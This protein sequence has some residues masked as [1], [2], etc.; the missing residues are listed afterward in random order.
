MGNVQSQQEFEAAQ[1][2]AKE[3]GRQEM[4]KKLEELD[5]VQQARQQQ[6]LQAAFEKGQAD[7]MEEGEVSDESR[8]DSGAV[9]GGVSV[10]KEKK[11][12]PEE[13]VI[14]V[15]REPKVK[16]AASS[17]RASERAAEKASLLDREAAAANELAAARR[18]SSRPGPADP[19]N[20]WS[21]RKQPRQK[22]ATEVAG[23]VTSSATSDSRRASS[24][25]RSPKRTVSESGFA[26]ER[27]RSKKPSISTSSPATPRSPDQ[28]SEDRQPPEWYRQMK[29]EGS[30][31]KEE[32]EAEPL[33]NGLKIQIRKAQDIIKK[34]QGQSRKAQI[35]L[36]PIFNEVRDKLH[37]VAF[38][39]VSK[40]GLRNT[41]ALDNEN[42]L[43]LI[44]DKRFDQG[45]SWPF[46]I[47]A[48]AE[49]L[50]NK[51]YREDFETDL[52][53]GIN[54]GKPKS[55]KDKDRND[56]SSDRLLDDY[57]K[58]DGNYYGNGKLLNGQWWPTQLT[59][60]RDGA[61]ASSQGGISGGSISL[62]E[63]AY[64]CIMSGGH[65]YGHDEDHGDWAW[66]CGTDC[67]DGTGNITESTLR[68][69]HS[70][71]KKNPVRLIRS[72]NLKSKW[73]PIK[74]F[75]YD[76]LYDVVEKERI[77]PEGNPRARYRFK[78]VRRDGQ[79]PIRGGDGPERRPTVQEVEAYEKDKRLRGF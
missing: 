37:K 40:K 49:E 33:L 50:Y 22:A 77:D 53:R 55:G 72:H 57:P 45:V 11:E 10:K 13:E 23:R 35:E 7:A 67:T 47:R 52:M 27:R 73:A 18:N 4:R 26:D 30:R 41:R 42:G 12:E 64:S 25:V 74:G 43:P 20:A 59:C 54:C 63:G 61:H 38:I 56:R 36:Q 32:S 75:R 62:Q 29:F 68:M 14:P 2:A 79:D 17:E 60:L 9:G 28:A 66:Y 65:G 6:A 5:K 70:V 24:D 1:A 39:K 44:F 3:Q 15:K 69:I 46:D 78:L 21:A 76:G 34:P 51:W 71:G 31:G 8:R 48:D 16:E 58:I 19:L